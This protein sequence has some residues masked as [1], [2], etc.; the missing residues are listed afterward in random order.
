MFDGILDSLGLGDIGGWL[1]GIGDFIGMGTGGIP[2]GSL[3]TGALGMMGS[4]DT[5]SANQEMNGRNLAFNASEAATNRDFQERMRATQYQTAVGDMKAAGLNPMLA[6]QNGGAGTPSG[7]QASATPPIAMKNNY[8]ASLSAAAQAADIQNKAAQTTNI[9]QDTQLKQQQIRQSDSEINKN[10]AS[11]GNITQQTENLKQAIPQIQAQIANTL[12]DTQLKGA[13]IGKTKAQTKLTE[14][15]VQLT[16]IQTELT[17]G[18]ITLQQAQT[19][20]QDTLQMLDM[21]KI[22]AAANSSDLAKTLPGTFMQNLNQMMRGT[23]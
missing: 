1:G 6:Y 15:Q 10:V 18:T 22:P 11:A 3:A 23:K 21:L 14:A 4:Q 5:N 16:G 13:E 8:S 2:W 20:V 19:K 12:T 9:N 7:S 17:K